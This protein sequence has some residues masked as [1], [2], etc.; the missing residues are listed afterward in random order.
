MQ[1]VRY[2][3]IFFLYTIKMFQHMDEEHNIID[4]NEMIHNSDEVTLIKNKENIKT[5][6][7]EEKNISFVFSESRFFDKFL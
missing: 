4:N 7:N 3:L 2:A 1:N 5:V 6:N